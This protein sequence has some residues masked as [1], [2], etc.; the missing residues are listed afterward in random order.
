MYYYCL[1]CMQRRVPVIRTILYNYLPT[2]RIISPQWVQLKWVKGVSFEEEHPLFPGYLFLYTEEP[3]ANFRS[4][5]TIDGVVRFLGVRDDGFQLCHDDLQFAKMLLECDGR[6]GNF[7]VY[8]VGDRIHLAKGVLAGFDG[9]IVKVDRN[10]RRL[11]VEFTFDNVI[12]KIT[13][14]YEMLDD[15]PE[16]TINLPLLKSDE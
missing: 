11:Q 3:I 15:G 6:V 16:T 13:V 2:A 9:K 8:Q 1:F 10:R 5:M 12:R 4:I 7:K 14:G